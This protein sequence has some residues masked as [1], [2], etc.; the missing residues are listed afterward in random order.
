FRHFDRLPS[1]AGPADDPPV[2]VTL[3][4]NAGETLAN[5]FVV[6][7]NQNANHPA[8]SPRNREVR[9]LSH[10]HRFGVSP[11]W[12][13]AR[14]LHLNLPP[15]PAGRREWTRMPITP[16]SRRLLAGRSGIRARVQP[17]RK[18]KLLKCGPMSADSGYIR[19]T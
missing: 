3:L 17:R 14:I 15:G 11:N 1:V 4:Q 12:R 5:E 10:A 6:V 16:R 2:L 13:N 19:P 18:R 9:A 7:G 8:I